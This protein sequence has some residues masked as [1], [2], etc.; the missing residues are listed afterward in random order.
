MQKNSEPGS[1]EVQDLLENWSLTTTTFVPDERPKPNWDII[2]E[3]LKSLLSF[4]NTS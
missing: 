4:V 3:E 1:F 2:R